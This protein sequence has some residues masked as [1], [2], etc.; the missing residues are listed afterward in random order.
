LGL[1]VLEIN[2]DGWWRVRINGQEG[3]APATLLVELKAPEA[4]ITATPID[5]VFLERKI[6]IPSL[7]FSLTL[8][9][10]LLSLSPLLS[11]SL[12]EILLPVHPSIC[13]GYNSC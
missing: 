8:L 9:S 1:Q 6:K 2:L 13:S 7:S 11:L 12:L 4:Q 5:Q 10:L 3:W